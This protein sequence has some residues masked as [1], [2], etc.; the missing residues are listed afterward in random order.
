MGEDDLTNLTLLL[1][2]FGTKK[3]LRGIKYR[4]TR[5]NWEE[6]ADML[7][8]TNEFDNRFQMSRDHSDNL[9]DNIRDAITGDYLRSL[10]STSGNKPITP[11]SILAMGLMFL[12]LPVPIPALADLFGVSVASAC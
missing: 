9:L 6:Y 7:N 5:K 2:V 12:S 11:K 4:H 3:R 8:Q 1:A 10:N